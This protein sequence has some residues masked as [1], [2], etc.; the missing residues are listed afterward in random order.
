[1]PTT[2]SPLDQCRKPTGWLGRLTLRRMNWSHAKLTTWGLKHIQVAEDATILDVGCGGGKTVKRLAAMARRGKVYGVDYADASV[3]MSR[4]T[5][6]RWITMGRVEL[7]RASVSRLPFADD[8]FSL[9]TAVE[10]HFFWPDLAADVREVRRVLKPGGTFIVI[11]E[12]FR[13]AHTAASKLLEKYASVAGMTL[14]TVDEHRDLL[15]TGGYSDVAVDADGNKGWI[16][17][18]GRKSA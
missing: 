7:Q 4:R 11:A 3:T 1:M 12:V 10:T 14:L 16:C 5:N 9:V 8:S 6:A 2:A 15:L 17:A 13:G 18:I